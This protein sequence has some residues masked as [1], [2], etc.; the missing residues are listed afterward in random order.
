VQN[1]VMV[2]MVFR[3][4]WPQLQNNGENGGPQEFYTVHR[5]EFSVGTLQ[6][7]VAQ[8]GLTNVQGYVVE[9]QNGHA[10]ISFDDDET[11]IFNRSTQQAYFEFIWNMDAIVDFGVTNEVALN[12]LQQP[13]VLATFSPASD[14]T[15]RVVIRAVDAVPTWR[16]I[17]VWKDVE[18]LPFSAR[19]AEAFG[20]VMVVVVIIVIWRAYFS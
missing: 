8:L 19:S 16:I 20:S 1:A 15:V 7:G 9:N 4:D 17:I 3:V 2:C 12:V 11:A 6:Q 10:F 13:T 14:D 5:L 18:P